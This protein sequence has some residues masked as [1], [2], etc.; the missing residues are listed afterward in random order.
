VRASELLA[1]AI[2]NGLVR[3]SAWSSSLLLWTYDGWGGWYDHVAPPQVDAAGYGF[4]VP[5]LLVS[6]FARRGYIDHTQLD[7]TSILRFIEDDWGLQPLAGRDASA[8]TFTGALDLNNP[9]REPVLISATRV[10]SSAPSPERSIIFVAYGLAIVLAVG[11][12]AVAAIRSG[13]PRRR[14]QA[15]RIRR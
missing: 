12:I 5:A 2:I 11:L 14:D 9:G 7:Y 13:R 10:A 15:T 1:Q 3:S 4:R 8:N 6:P